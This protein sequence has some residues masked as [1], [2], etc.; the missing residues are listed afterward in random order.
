MRS[1]IHIFIVFPLRISDHTLQLSATCVGRDESQH[2]SEAN[3]Y[4]AYKYQRSTLK[5]GICVQLEQST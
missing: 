2:G 3:L 1:D 5:V 4:R